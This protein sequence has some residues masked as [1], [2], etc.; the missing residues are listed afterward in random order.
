MTY[1]AIKR[2]LRNKIYHPVYFLYG[3]ESYFVDDIVQIIEKEVLNEGEKAFNQ[4]ILYGKE[5]NVSQVVETA[6]R[7]PMMSNYQVVILKEAQYLRQIEK[8]EIYLKQPVKTTILVI[9]FKHKKPDK[10]K[11]F[12]KDL[13]KQSV[14]LESNKLYE[15]QVPA[16]I[17]HFLQGHS[18]QISDKA[19]QLLTDYLGNDLSKI[20]NELRKIIINKEP[21][22]EITAEDVETYSGI[23]KDYNVFELQSALGARDVEKTYKIVK[24]INANPRSNPLVLLLGSLYT[25]F[26]KIYLLHFSQSLPDRELAALMSVNPRFMWQYKDAARHYSAD[27]LEQIMNWLHEY[28]MKSKGVNNANASDGQLLKELVFNILS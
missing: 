1:E 23:S 2:D 22:S 3:E 16:W 15:N 9:A 7:L 5:V 25:F 19:S 11:K 17:S 18:V 14:V 21:Q 12:F 6:R 27:K 10:R 26:S 28:D 8:L 24:Y 20:V 4:S 13:I